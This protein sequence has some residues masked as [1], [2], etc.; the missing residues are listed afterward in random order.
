[1]SDG[2]PVAAR[3][4]R[5]TNIASAV[6]YST[7]LSPPRARSFPRVV[8]WTVPVALAGLL[9]SALSGCSTASPAAIVNGQA[10]SQQQLDQQLQ[11][12]GSSSEYVKAE[13]QVFV[14]QY[15]Q[16]ASQGQQGQLY[17]VEAPSATGVGTYGAVWSDLE[18]SNMIT[19]LAIRQHLARLHLSAT[20]V[21]VDAA[22]ASQYAANP[23]EWRQL[24]RSVRLLA[25]Q[26]DADRALV[27]GPPATSSQDKIFYK[28]NKPDF[29]SQL[30]LTTVN[31]SVPGTGGGVNMA[32]SKKEA[33][34]VA[35]ALS[36]HTGPGTLPATSGARYCDSPE[37]FIEQ[38]L[39]FQSQV[40][41]LAPG[42]ATVL[43][44]G[45]GYQV[46]EVRSRALIP[47]NAKVAADIDVTA[48]HGGSQNPPNGDTKVIKVLMATRVEVNPA[49]GS[50]SATLP[51]G[52]APQ[53]V[54][55]IGAACVG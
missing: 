40:A 5:P 50:W 15:E 53:V 38:P 10:I 20:P 33:D 21:E 34:E 49:Y 39:N 27:D 12:W 29:W 41:V 8:R 9:T 17:T 55:L 52:C 7:F 54:A 6:S 11:E 13:D 37:Q 2:S 35:N 14:Q 24:S 48:T 30:C 4:R 18:L 43:S 23:N 46:V 1:M 3:S 51:Q 32:A 44:E 42:H 28:D 31:I 19:A 45:A 16:A 47:Y 26:A 36:G 25:A 22:W